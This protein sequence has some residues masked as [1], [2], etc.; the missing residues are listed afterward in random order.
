VL[1]AMVVSL[2]SKQM[3]FTAENCAEMGLFIDLLFLCLRIY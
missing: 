1:S 3:L 2:H